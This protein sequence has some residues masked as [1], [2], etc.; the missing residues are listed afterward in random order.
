M[1]RSLTGSPHARSR[2]YQPDC[3]S[4]APSRCP[5]SLGPAAD[6]T[7]APSASRR[8]LPTTR[9]MPWTIAPSARDAVTRGSFCRSEP[10]AALRGLAKAGLPASCSDSFSRSNAASDRNTS[11]RTSS[12]SGTSSPVRRSGTDLIVLTFSVTSSPVRPSPLVAA[13]VRRPRS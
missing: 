11:P 13:L 10:A 6:P 9:P 12:S 7:M 5:S 4:G 2:S 3:V 8:T 1:Y